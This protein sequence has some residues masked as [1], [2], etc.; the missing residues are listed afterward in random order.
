MRASF[1]LGIVLLLAVVTTSDGSAAALVD[2]LVA[3]VENVPILQSD[4]EHAVGL[5]ALE[6]G[7]TPESM[8][9]DE[10]RAVLE[11]LVDQQLLRQQM[12]DENTAIA[13]E[14]DVARQLEKIR[15]DYP[16]VKSDEDW[17][18]LLAK[19][20]IDQDMLH[21]DVA[22]QLQVLR[23]VDLRLRPE[24]HV[25]REEIETYYR[26]TLVPEVRRRGGKEQDLA[27]VYPQIEEIL[28]QQRIDALLNTWLQDLR[29][30][31]SIQWLES[32]GNRSDEVDGAS[33]SGG[34]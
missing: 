32:D 2:R 23:F 11:R 8:S 26:E 34:R 31:S 21:R 6:Q 4:W 25:R 9:T 7:R 12:G 20:G 14:R 10:R 15:S 29:G 5:E 33:S 27:E 13:E 16:Q 19:Y 22:R 24:S 28:R 17:Q 3:S 30:H 18:Q 1:K